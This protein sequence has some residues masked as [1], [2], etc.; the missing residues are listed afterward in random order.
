MIGESSFLKQY[1]QEPPILPPSKQKNEVIDIIKIRDF[2][3]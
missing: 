3:F 2:T 1:Q